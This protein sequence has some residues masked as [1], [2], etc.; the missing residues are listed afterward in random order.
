M[1]I[2]A[3]ANLAQRLLSRMIVAGI[4][5][6]GVYG[7]CVGNG[8]EMVSGQARP[9]RRHH[10]GGIRRGLRADGRANPVD[11]Q[12]LRLPD[13]LPLLRVLGQGIIIVIPRLL[14]VRAE[15]GQVPAVIQNANVIQTRRNY[16]PTEVI[17][18]PIFLADVFHVRDRRRR[19][20]DGSPPISKPI[21]V[22]WKVRQRAV[23]LMAMTMT[24]VTFAA[25]IDRVLNGLTRAFSSAGSPT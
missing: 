1:A 22:D 13:Y 15:D 9:C 20:I 25:T 8:A 10:R 4:G 6:G 16:Q 11:D 21:A 24:A 7:T 19:R 14:P 12:G 23:T 17:R 5:A 3:E 2:N 18:H